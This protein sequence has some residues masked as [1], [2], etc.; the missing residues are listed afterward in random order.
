[1]NESMPRKRADELFDAAFAAKWVA[2]QGLD[3][4]SGAAA[5]LAEGFKLAARVFGDLLQAPA[6]D[7]R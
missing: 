2:R 1:M 3:A 7:P 4:V 6:A 5:T